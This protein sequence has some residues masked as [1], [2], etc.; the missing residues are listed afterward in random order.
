MNIWEK[1]IE[2]FRTPADVQRWVD[3]HQEV[4]LHV[5]RSINLMSRRSSQ[6]VQRWIEAKAKF[7][8]ATQPGMQEDYVRRQTIA[9]EEQVLSARQALWTSLSALMVSA[10]ALVVS[11]WPLI[12]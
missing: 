1:E 4:Y 5:L 8:E 2:D 3:A 6:V 10:A 11:A 9:A 12:K 7:A